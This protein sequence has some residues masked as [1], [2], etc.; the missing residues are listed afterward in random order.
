[1]DLFELLLKSD[2]Q[3]ISDL[4][5]QLDRERIDREWD[6]K[7]LAAENSELRLRLALLVRLLIEKQLI[8]AEEY[9]AL[10]TAAERE[11]TP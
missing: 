5:R 4:R 2:R 10:I 9:A 7:S 1:M 3:R 11:A 8:T 6:A